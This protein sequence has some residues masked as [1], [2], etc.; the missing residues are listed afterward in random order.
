LVLEAILR[1]REIA[2]RHDEFMVCAAHELATP[3]ATM[4]GWLTLLEALEPEQLAAPARDALPVFKR[5]LAQLERLTQDLRDAGQLAAR[6]FSLSL[7]PVDLNE[8]ARAA[9]ASFTLLAAQKGILLE[10]SCTSD[11]ALVLGDTNRLQQVINNLIGNSL[12]F[13]PRG[14]HIALSVHAGSYDARLTV[15]DNGIGIA[16]PEL[17]RLFRR[18]AQGEPREGGMGLG[19]SLARE[20]VEQHSGKLSATSAGEGCGATFEIVLPKADLRAEEPG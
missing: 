12:K 9:G 3:L 18:F 14:G 17:N 11:P 13:T 15:R 19:L 7:K 1:D 8:L 5:S 16:P 20:I 4:T 6:R 10:V 2:H